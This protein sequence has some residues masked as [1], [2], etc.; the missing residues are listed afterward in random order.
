MINNQQWTQ[1]RS[2]VRIVLLSL[3]LTTLVSILLLFTS[4]RSAFAQSVLKADYRFQNTRSSSAGSAPPLKDIGPKTN[5]FT[6]DTVDGTSRTVLHFPKGNG[7]KLSP[8]SSVVS[9]GTYTIVVL[10]KLNEVDGYRRIIDFKNGTSDNGLYI[11]GGLLRFYPQAQ[12]NT[13]IAPSTYVQVVL[14]RNAGGT[15]TGYVNGVQQFSFDDSASNDAVIDANTL[16]FFRDNESGGVATEHSAGSVA[17]IRLYDSALNA[18]EVGAL[19]RLDYIVNS[20]LDGSDINLSDGKCSANTSNQCTLR[21]AIQQANATQG[22]NTIYFASGLGGAI[23]L[24]QGQLQIANDP[25]SQTDLT[26]NGPGARKLTVSANNASRVLEIASG[27]GAAI[28]GLTISNG[29]VTGSGGGILNSGGTLALTNSTVRDNTANSGFGGGINNNGGTLTLT[30]STVSGNTANHTPPFG[31]GGVGGGI[32]NNNSGTLT[33]T[34]STVSGNQGTF[35]TGGIGNFGAGS[36]ITLTNS[37]VTNNLP[38]GIISEGPATVVNTI[39]AGNGPS[40]VS[41]AQGAFASQGYNLIGK[42]DGSSGFTRP[43]DQTG[44]IASPLDP[45]L[46]PLANNGGPTNT[47]ALLSSSTAIDKGL[48]IGYPSA[49]QRGVARPEDGDGDGVNTCDIGAFEVANTAPTIT[50]LKPAPGSK[51]RDRTPSVAATVRDDHT[52]LAKS[53]IK[54]FV[55]GKQKSTFSYDAPKNRLSY[56][57]GRLS[58]GS[59]TVKIVATDGQLSTTRSWSFKVVR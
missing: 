17:R 42:A 38:G 32:Y 54:L 56:T 9:N 52:N 57:S 51:T 10:F 55:D 43:G 16:R 14:T 12:G 34:N 59:H 40:N 39:V 3:A 24:T 36:R 48:N 6:P 29:N 8:T 19:D 49:D 45:K 18:G 22:A 21:A 2:L 33:L 25:A 1:S 26:I 47:H 30:N 58:F 37:T 13:T 15:V 11:Q 23:T 31:G 4:P 28:N 50:N 27:A 44:T 41:D 53:N 46:G 5:T 20:T 7:L 35:S